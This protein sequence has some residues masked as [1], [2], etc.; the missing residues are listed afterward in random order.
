MQMEVYK[1]QAKLDQNQSDGTP[2]EKKPEKSKA[3]K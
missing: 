1:A 2:T 3:K